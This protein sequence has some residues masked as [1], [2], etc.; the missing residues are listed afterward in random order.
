MSFRSK[1]DRS[2]QKMEQ[3]YR[4]LIISE[5]R[6]RK[7]ILWQEND[8]VKKAPAKVEKICERIVGK[9]RR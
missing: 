4:N 9:R 7:K 5:A 2:S 6:V 8:E 1:M 3:R